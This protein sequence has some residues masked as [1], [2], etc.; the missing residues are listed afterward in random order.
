MFLRP[1]LNHCP[2]SQVGAPGH[3]GETMGCT[4]ESHL[5]GDLI[6]IKRK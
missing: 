6:F 2:A 5:R 3:L 1:H 4:V